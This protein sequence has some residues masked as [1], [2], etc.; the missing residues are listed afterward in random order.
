MAEQERQLQEMHE[1]LLKEELERS[2]REKRI[3]EKEKQLVQMQV[4]F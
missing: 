4:P 3:L 2:E 1:A